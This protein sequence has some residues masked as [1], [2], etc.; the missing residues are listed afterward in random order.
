MASHL[1]VTSKGFDEVAANVRNRETPSFHGLLSNAQTGDHRSNC[2]SPAT[3]GAALRLDLFFLV[4]GCCVAVCGVWVWG[5][6][7]PSY[8]VTTKQITGDDVANNYLSEHP[9]RNK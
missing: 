9:H 6:T 1:A 2:V 4:C 3:R 8:C 7:D 5:V